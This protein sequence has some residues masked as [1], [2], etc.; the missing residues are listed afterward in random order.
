MGSVNN[1]T[2]TYQ[3]RRNSALLLQM[4]PI[5]SFSSL[6]LSDAGQYICEILGDIN[7][8][9]DVFNVTLQGKSYNN[10]KNMHRPWAINHNIIP[11][12]VPTPVMSVTGPDS[13]IPYN[14]TIYNLTGTIQ[15]DM[16]IVNM[17]IIVATWVWTL[18]GETLGVFETVAPV[19]QSVLMFRPL[20]TNS[21]GEYHL[22]VTLTSLNNTDYITESSASTTYYISV[23]RK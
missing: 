15:L 8:V 3:W 21:S 17:D 23:L 10:Y 9:S 22:I 19:Y 6:Q 1:L 11:N 13:V 14:G 7:A 4:G 18:A 12:A 5:L 16:S 20:A 2:Y